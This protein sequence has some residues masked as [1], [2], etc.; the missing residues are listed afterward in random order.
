MQRTITSEWPACVRQDWL[1]QVFLHNRTN[2]VKKYVNIHCEEKT[3]WNWPIWQNCCQESTVEEAKQCQKAPVR[4]YLS[5]PPTRQNFTQGQWHEGR[6][7]WGLGEGKVW[8]KPRLEPYWTMMLLTSP[9]VAQPLLDGARNKINKV[10]TIE[11]RNRVLRS[12]ELNSKTL[13]QIV[14]RRID[15]RAEPTVS[16][17]P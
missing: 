12:D 8:H 6:L 5:L 13:A 11:Q 10:W 16:H 4:R 2:D 17:Q 14:R 7:K 15:E 3:P 9:K 1:L